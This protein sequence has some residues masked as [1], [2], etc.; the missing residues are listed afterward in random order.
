RSQA[1]AWSYGSATTE[2]LMR[3]LRGAVIVE[4]REVGRFTV[5]DLDY[6]LGRMSPPA[7]QTAPAAGLLAAAWKT[8]DPAANQAKRD[9]IQIG[10]AAIQAIVK[11]FVDHSGQ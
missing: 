2:A 10:L 11:L 8:G 6:V 3:S 9:G 7:G 1:R 5:R 4:S